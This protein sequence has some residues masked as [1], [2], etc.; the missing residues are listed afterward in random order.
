MIRRCECPSNSG[1]ASYGGRGITVCSEW[2]SFE[3]FISDMGERPAGMSLGRLN[4]SKGY[5]KSNCEWQTR[6]KQNSER[7]SVKVIAFKGLIMHQSDWSRHFGIKV[8]SL[9]H[10]IKRDG[11]T[12]AMEHY[13]RANLTVDGKLLHP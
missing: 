4:H 12:G 7:S 11:V 8:Q 1:Y 3:V 6:K 9:A 5:S 10:R 2:H 13:W